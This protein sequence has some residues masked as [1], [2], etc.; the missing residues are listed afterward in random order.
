MAAIDVWRQAKAPGHRSPRDPAVN[1][2]EGY[3]QR[4]RLR[5]LGAALQRS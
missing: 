2:L 5:P 3:A 1:A 4:G